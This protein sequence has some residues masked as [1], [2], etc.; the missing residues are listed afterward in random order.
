VSISHS[1]ITGDIHHYG[2]HLL[3][4]LLMRLS[5][6][7]PAEGNLETWALC[8]AA[9]STKTLKLMVNPAQIRHELQVKL[10]VLY[11][12]AAEIFALTVFL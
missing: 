1:V 12:C 6:L 3:E 2:M 9:I 8:Q 5:G 7:L 4:G 10:G 11:E